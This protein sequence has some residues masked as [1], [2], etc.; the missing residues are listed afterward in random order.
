MPF[1]GL[2]QDSPETF[3]RVPFFTGMKVLSVLAGTDFSLCL[4]RPSEAADTSPLSPEEADGNINKSAS[5]S[6]TV[7][8]ASLSCPLG[9]SIKPAAATLAAHPL[10]SL[11][12]DHNL[13]LT[14]VP[15]SGGSSEIC[16]IIGKE[17]CNGA[18]SQGLDEVDG[19]ATR[20][21]PMTAPNTHK[22]NGVPSIFGLLA[23][24]FQS[25]LE[26][27]S[28]QENSPLARTA[29]GPCSLSVDDLEC[30][31]TACPA[32]TR[33]PLVAKRS[34]SMGALSQK[35]F[36]L[37]EAAAADLTAE[38]RRLRS[39]EV[40]S[41]GAGSRGQLG[42]GDMLARP[43]PAP[44]PGLQ[45]VYVVKVAVGQHHVVAMTG[46][47]LVYGWGDNSQGQACPTDSLAVVLH[48][49]RMQIP[50]EETA[51]DIAACG[52]CSAVLMDSG[53]IYVSGGGG[54]GKS[55]RLR[56]IPADSLVSDIELRSVAAFLLPGY[57]IINTVPVSE[58]MANLVSKEKVMLRQVESVEHLLHT[59]L[60]PSSSGTSA[61]IDPIIQ[62]VQLRLSEASFLL[63]ACT[64]RSAG[65]LRDFTQTGL[66]RHRQAWEESARALC[67]AICDC[68]AADSLYLDANQAHHQHLITELLVSRFGLPQSGVQGQAGLEQ[69]LVQVMKITESYIRALAALFHIRKAVGREEEREPED[70]ERRMRGLEG[71]LA[72]LMGLLQEMERERQVAERTR[73][74]W[75]SIG[76]SSSRLLEIQMP[77]APSRRLVLDS[78]YQPVSLSGAMTKHWLLLMSDLLVDYGY[79]LVVH[80][81]ET[82]WL[83]SLPAAASGSR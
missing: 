30:R 21:R 26:K 80:P 47:G 73:H 72:G 16:D 43:T 25:P 60:P 55:V 23:D 22:F 41:W 2:V 83:E 5:A 45:G 40:W 53:K 49:A 51:R 3:V 75:K 74:F 14:Q 61:A 18:V 29:G 46:S 15:S 8:G 33:L 27:I 6:E 54:T 68:I 62:T 57:T 71:G 31:E 48:P 78:R 4:V 11:Q 20:A 67:R 1:C 59:L 81:L 82:I 77:A 79:Q 63:A 36:R 65:C 7:D 13:N 32:P 17:S 50:Q 34:A 12:L 28:L 38:G 24:S 64:N 39:T 52:N 76:T 70:N 35:G 44:I 10:M 37:K 42:Q 19:D 56:V 69:I 58:E 66:Y 9:L